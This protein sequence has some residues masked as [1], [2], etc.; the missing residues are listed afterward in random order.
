MGRKHITLDKQTEEIV[1][2]L[3][4]IEICYL[5]K[6]GNEYKANKTNQQI[7]HNMAIEMNAIKQLLLVNAKLV[8]EKSHEE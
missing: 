5:I 8:I 1:N 7:L 3:S 4:S 6:L 2:G